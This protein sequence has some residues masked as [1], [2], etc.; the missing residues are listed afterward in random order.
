MGGGARYPKFRFKF[1]LEEKTNT[2][3]DNWKTVETDCNR[4]NSVELGHGPLVLTRSYPK[5]CRFCSQ[6][7]EPITKLVHLIWPNCSRQYHRLPTLVRNHFSTTNHLP[8]KDEF[9]NFWINS[10]RFFNWCSIRYI[11][12][13]WFKKI[14][15]GCVDSHGRWFNMKHLRGVSKK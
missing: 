3:C 11:W 4:C 2:F 6:R 9:K 12:Q 14:G 10:Q 1:N 13:K 5:P 15:R 8:S 7:E